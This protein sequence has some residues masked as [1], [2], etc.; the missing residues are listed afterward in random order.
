MSLVE[1]MVVI[2]I[3][4]TLMSV[5]AYG[6]FSIYETAR[7]QM[8]ALQITKVAERVDV[9]ALN[10]KHPPSTAEGLA[11]VY[12]SEPIPRDQWDRQLMYTSPGTNGQPYDVFSYGKDGVEG[13]DDDIHLA[14]AQR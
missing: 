8:T 4:L 2:A 6:V 11:A 5:L 1:I 3:L 9:Y 7:G 10:K 14:D 13:G 12:G